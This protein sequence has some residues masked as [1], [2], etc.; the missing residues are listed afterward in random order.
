MHLNKTYRVLKHV[1]KIQAGK[2]L[3]KREFAFLLMQIQISTTAKV[4]DYPKHLNCD[5]PY[6]STYF[7]G[8]L[9]F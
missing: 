6:D 9:C 8:F 2:G 1:R 3:R 4:K 7:L 5:F